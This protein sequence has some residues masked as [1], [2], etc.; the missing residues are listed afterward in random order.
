MENCKV[1][2]IL[3]VHGSDNTST[4]PMIQSLENYYDGITEW[5]NR[6]K[7]CTQS[8]FI[9]EA[10]KYGLD[11]KFAINVIPMLSPFD[12]KLQPEPTLTWLMEDCMW[13]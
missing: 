7:V 13:M 6:A 8:H 10:S 11:K 2:E 1:C 4:W 12:T 9:V 5:W 3:K